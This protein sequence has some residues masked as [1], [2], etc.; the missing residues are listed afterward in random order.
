MN[1]DKYLS[2]E[3]NEKGYNCLSFAADVWLEISGDNRL[4]SIKLGEGYKHNFKKV[5]EN[6]FENC[7][8]IGH[9]SGPH[10]GIKIGEQVI[11]C[12]NKFTI[13][14][15]LCDFKDNFKRVDFYI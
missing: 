5:T 4:H 14:E 15:T 12:A 8:V 2:L 7:I 1:L 13:L 9:A 10:I 6:E 11:H 3:H